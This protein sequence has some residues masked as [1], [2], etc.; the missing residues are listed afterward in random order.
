MW[1]LNKTMGYIKFIRL[2]SGEDLISFVEKS[3][4]SIKLTYPLNVMLHFNT[5]KDTQEMMLSFWLP[6]NLL[7]KNY[8]V[9]P[10]SEILLI[11][12]PKKDFQEYYLNFLNDFE[13][14]NAK[15]ESE[16]GKSDIQLI[17][18]GMDAKNL[19]KMH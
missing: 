15:E 19:N 9:L 6:L 5:K 4:N 14:D 18:E 16:I 11:L 1:I 13:F 10:L 7:E 3:P 8:A 17:L 2:K 12:E